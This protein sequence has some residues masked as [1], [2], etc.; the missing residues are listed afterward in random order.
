MAVP[1]DAASEL[2]QESVR[3]NVRKSSLRYLVQGGVLVL[4]GF[5]AII[6]PVISSEVL[7]LALGWLLIISGAIQAVSLIAIRNSPFAGLQLVSTVLA[8]LIGVLILRNPVESLITLTLLVVVFF[9]IEGIARITW[10]LTIRP[11]DGWIWVLLSGALG[12][13]LSIVLIFTLDTTATWLISL[14]VGIQLIAIGASIG[15]LAWSVR[16]AAS[17][18]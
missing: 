13:V 4:A 2:Y 1:I 11:L 17:T 5:L 14:L 10:A 7:V 15:F 9:M 16:K 6:F 12:V 18:K 3:N 8:L